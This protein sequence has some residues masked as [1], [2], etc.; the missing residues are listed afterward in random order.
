MADRCKSVAGTT[1]ASGEGA[2][3]S[4]F[5]F[6][7]FSFFSFSEKSMR[8]PAAFYDGDMPHRGPGRNGLG[9]RYDK[10]TPNGVDRER[11]RPTGGLLMRRTCFRCKQHKPF[12]D[13]KYIRTKS[14]RKFIC[15][16]CK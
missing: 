9:T 16:E 8:N 3:D 5:A 1:A 2:G 15:K 6:G 12:V 10:L 13:C 11:A 14:G 4:A 7:C